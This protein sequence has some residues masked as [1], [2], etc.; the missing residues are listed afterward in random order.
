MESGRDAWCYNSSREKLINNIQNTINFYNSELSRWQASD[1]SA[2]IEDFINTDSTKIKWTRSLRN[3]LKKGIFGDFKQD[4]I[5][6]SIYRPYTKFYCLNENLLIHEKG[7]MPRIFPN[8][9]AKNR[10]IITTGVGSR[11]GFA[12][13]M[14][15]CLPNLHTLDTGQCFPLYLYEAKSS[16][17]STMDSM[18]TSSDDPMDGYT[19]KDGISDDALRHFQQHYADLTISREDIFYY[20]YGL[21]HSPD[22][23][24]R[25][26][27]NLSKELARI[28]CTKQKSDFCA[29]AE[30]GRQLAELHVGHEQLEPYP[31][32]FTKGDPATTEIT[33][34][35]QFY[36][37][38]ARVGNIGVVVIRAGLPS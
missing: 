23:R 6:L 16:A 26:A 10:V 29:F 5:M 25:Y 12:C 28:P 30:I 18:F 38:K 7:Q 36:R 34:P 37:V 24:N 4:V 15:D 3:S 14:V 9:A 1:K 8:A 20:I 32:T 11:S 13:L 33:D 31:V 17:A 2:P 22:Y 35:R 21:L 19:R 27:D